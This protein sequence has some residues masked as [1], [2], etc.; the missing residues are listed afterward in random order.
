MQ[1]MMFQEK[2][3]NFAT[4][5]PAA[6]RRGTYVMRITEDRLLADEILARIPEGRRPTGAVRRTRVA[7]V[8]M[9]PLPRVGNPVGVLFGGE[10]PRP[11]AASAR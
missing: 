10:A 8:E 3:I 6:F 1:E 2:G 5:Y 11:R 9:P 4:D 7:A